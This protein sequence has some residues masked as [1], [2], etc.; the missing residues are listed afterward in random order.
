MI[1]LSKEWIASNI[2]PKV[3]NATIWG[4]I[5]ILIFY[6]LPLMLFPHNL[7][8]NE[9]ASTLTEFAVISVSFTIIG[10]LLKGTIAGCCFGIIR[11][12]ILI[13]FFFT[14]SEGGLLTM[15]VPV[16]EV[17]VNISVDITLILLMIVS[18]NLLDIAKNLLDAINLLWQKPDNLDLD[19]I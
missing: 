16:S 18:V 4:S 7:L 1:K 13:A 5:T 6:Y 3:L 15:T 8:P 12:F 9:F 17:V 2:L 19:E 10:Q 14:I 11:A